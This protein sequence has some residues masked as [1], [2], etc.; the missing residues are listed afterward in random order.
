MYDKNRG[1]V[2]KYVLFFMN[3]PLFLSTFLKKR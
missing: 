2:N 3:T 1:S